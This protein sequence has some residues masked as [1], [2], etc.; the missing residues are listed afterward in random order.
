MGHA[1]G[2]KGPFGTVVITMVTVHSTVVYETDALLSRHS[3][4]TADMALE[5]CTQYGPR[6]KIIKK[7]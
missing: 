3:S 1:S 6:Q 4:H 2:V 7:Q 5:Y